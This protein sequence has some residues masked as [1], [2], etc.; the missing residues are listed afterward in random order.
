MTKAGKPGAKK[1]SGLVLRFHY[2][3]GDMRLPLEDY[4]KAVERD[5]R[6]LGQIAEQRAAEAADSERVVL[7][8]RKSRGVVAARNKDAVRAA[9]AELQPSQR[10]REATSLV[11]EKLL[12]RGI[13][14]A[15][16]TV[17]KHLD[18]I[19]SEPKSQ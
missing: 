15:R 9:F 6:L 18:L 4:L 1:A 14:M 19:R 11:L 17:K 8:A 12:N 10:G 7:R 5:A 16:G 13:K 2:D 3:D